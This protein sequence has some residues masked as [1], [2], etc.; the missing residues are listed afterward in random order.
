MVAF[1]AMRIGGKG[2]NAGAASSS[3]EAA[4]E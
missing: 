2:K 3:V 1:R 4:K